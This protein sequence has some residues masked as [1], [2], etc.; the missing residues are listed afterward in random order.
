MDDVP[1]DEYQYRPGHRLRMSPA[2]IAVLGWVADPPG[3]DET[4]VPEVSYEVG[5]GPIQGMEIKERRTCSGVIV[6]PPP[7]RCYDVH[8]PCFRDF[9]HAY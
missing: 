5:L 6:R 3:L 8:R 1:K 2:K 9:Q 7:G 4:N